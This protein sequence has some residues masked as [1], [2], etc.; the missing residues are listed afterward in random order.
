MNNQTIR[1]DLP[2]PHTAANGVAF[3]GA[4]PRAYQTRLVPILFH[5]YAEDLA[6]RVGPLAP[7]A[8]LETA[9]GTG[10]VSRRLRA[11]LPQ[12]S[13]LTVSD[14]SS[15]MLSIARESLD[16]APGVEFVATDA[17]SLPFA[18]ESFDAVVCQFGVMFFPDEAA[19]YREAARV[20]KPGGRFVFNVWDDLAAN[21]L[22][23]CV[24]ETLASLAPADPPRFLEKPYRPLDLTRMLRGLQDAGFGEIRMTAL[25]KK[26]R[27]ESAPHAVQAFLQATPL[28]AQVAERGLDGDAASA[29]SRALA[30]RFARGDESAPFAVPMRAIVFEAT[31]EV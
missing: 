1:A 12:D 5:E 20:V 7:R 15:D 16:G 26:C 9:A 27:V 6:A 13:A 21:P 25:P 4:I 18:D 23:G 30:A 8:V 31:K 17:T 24:H 10:V 19:G 2:R 11:A 14:I 28:G 3:K 22:P 29:A